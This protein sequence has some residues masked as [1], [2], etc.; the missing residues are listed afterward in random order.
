MENTEQL[1][2]FTSP[3]GPIEMASEQTPQPSNS[4]DNNWKPILIIAILVVGGA[5]IVYLR[6]Q[7][8]KR[9]RLDQR[10]GESMYY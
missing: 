3:F 2:G 8:E 9:K 7:Q 1:I 5:G 6:I 10:K 4:S